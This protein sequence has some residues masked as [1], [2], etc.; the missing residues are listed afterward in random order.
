MINIESVSPDIY[1]RRKQLAGN[2]EKLRRKVQ[3]RVKVPQL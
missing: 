1:R 3:K 2:K